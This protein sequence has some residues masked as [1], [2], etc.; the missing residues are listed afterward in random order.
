MLISTRFAIWSKHQRCRA[1]VFALSA[2]ANFACFYE[3]RCSVGAIYIITIA[4]RHTHDFHT[5]SFLHQ[6]FKLWALGM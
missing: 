3:A 1:F 5:G 4:T 6:N 2:S